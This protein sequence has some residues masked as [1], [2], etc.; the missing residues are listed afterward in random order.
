MIRDSKTQQMQSMLAI[1][2]NEN[3]Q[4]TDLI[5]IEHIN[6]FIFLFLKYFFNFSVITLPA[7]IQIRSKQKRLLLLID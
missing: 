4:I 1:K 2:S 7:E 6:Q 5:E 3:N